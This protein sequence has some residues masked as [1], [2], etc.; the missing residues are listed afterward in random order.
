M[1]EDWMAFLASFVSPVATT[2]FFFTTSAVLSL[3]F[4]IVYVLF[5][6][7]GY[8]LLSAISEFLIEVSRGVPTVLFVL[9]MGNLGLAPYFSGIDVEGFIPGVAYGFG[10]A[11]SFII[12]GL[13]FSSSGH[14]ARI[15]EAAISTIK[16]DTID[17]METL[18]LGAFAKVRL[19]FFECAPALIPT[20]SARLVHHLH[21]TAFISM[22][23]IAGIFAAMRTGVIETAKVIPYLTFAT[24]LFVLL[25][26]AI[27][28][29][30]NVL[31]KRLL[32]R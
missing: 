11:A 29:A 4:A 20:V 26:T 24:L 10:L 17:Y 27:H 8:P 15:I 9:L 31:A 2:V 1:T 5:S 7:S 3:L 12:V 13:A 14:L 32:T 6:R 18:H 19:I 22:F 25:G 21:N 28:V 30:G 16:Q 23:P